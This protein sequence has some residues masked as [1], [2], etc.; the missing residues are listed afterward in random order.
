MKGYIEKGCKEGGW[1]RGIFIGEW[2]RTSGEMEGEGGD[3]EEGGAGDH[4]GRR[5]KGDG[6]ELTMGGEGGSGW[7]AMTET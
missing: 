4:R 1:D 7:R 6:G 5:K 3:E 2:L